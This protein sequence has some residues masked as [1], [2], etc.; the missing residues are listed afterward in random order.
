MTVKRPSE[1]LTH[2]SQFHICCAKVQPF[3]NLCQSSVCVLWSR[4]KDETF[5]TKRGRRVQMRQMFLQIWRRHGNISFAERPI[6][7]LHRNSREEKR[8]ISP[9]WRTST[10]SVVPA[11]HVTKGS[12]CCSIISRLFRPTDDEPT[13]SFRLNEGKSERKAQR[14]GRI[15]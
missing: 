1:C 14:K 10:F 12:G 3:S 13:R 15:E 9:L 2:S 4:N 11:P 8:S 7:I 6:S 5:V